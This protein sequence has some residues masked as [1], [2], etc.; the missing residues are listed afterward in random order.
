MVKP[1]VLGT[2]LQKRS[3]LSWW[4]PRRDHACLN[5]KS[6]SKI[7]IWRHT[8]K[9]LFWCK[10]LR[11]RHDKSFLWL[12]ETGTPTCLFHGVQG[13]TGS[14]QE[15][16]VEI[17]FQAAELGIQSPKFAWNSKKF[18]SVSRKS[19]SRSPVSKGGLSQ[20]WGGRGGNLRKLGIYG[21]HYYN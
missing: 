17:L 10:P 1:Q 16:T 3:V 20:L 9:T 7:W 15:S 14:P 2:T 11:D 21:K 13:S 18:S 6:W 8:D 4:I 12:S 19:D 5:T